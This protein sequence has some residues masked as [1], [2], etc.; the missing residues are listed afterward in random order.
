MIRFWAAL[1]VVAAGCGV[2]VDGSW[3]ASIDYGNFCQGT[4]ALKQQSGGDLTGSMD[5]GVISAAITDGHFDGRNVTFSIFET[6]VHPATITATTDG[7]IMKGTISG[8]G[9]DN[10]PFRAER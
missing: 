6:R 4:M 7:K 3:K 5:C 10:T 1:S 9:F 2:S 8:S